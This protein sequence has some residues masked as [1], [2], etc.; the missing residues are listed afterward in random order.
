VNGRDLAERL[1][2]SIGQP[3]Q[4]AAVKAVVAE[5]AADCSLLGPLISALA[6][7]AW[8]GACVVAASEAD[9]RGQPIEAVLPAAIGVLFAMHEPDEPQ[10]PTLTLVSM[11][12]HRPRADA[13]EAGTTNRDR[14]PQATAPGERHRDT[15]PAHQHR[16]MDARRRVRRARR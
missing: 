15:H 8:R 1:V 16:T 10:R 5:L 14:S 6:E 4:D 2:V 9:R 3:D 7:T 12:A 11:N 13:P